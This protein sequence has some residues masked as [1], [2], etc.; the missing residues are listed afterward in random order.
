MATV[1]R[2]CVDLLKRHNINIT[3][4]AAAADDDD[5]DDDD[6]D[7]DNNYGDDADE[8]VFLLS[9]LCQLYLDTDD[10]GKHFV[11]LS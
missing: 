11:L 1:A 7:G 10:G 9:A 6:D 4:A 3:A 2:L 5:D 8:V